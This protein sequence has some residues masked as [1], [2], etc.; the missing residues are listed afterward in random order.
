[1]QYYYNIVLSHTGYYQFP[2]QIFSHYNSFNELVLP[3]IG[4]FPKW[5]L[6]LIGSGIMPILPS[7]DS[8]I[9]IGMLLTG[10]SFIDMVVVP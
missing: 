5:L 2:V 10:P 6:F 3:W 8:F 4:V 9:T 7:L 1:M